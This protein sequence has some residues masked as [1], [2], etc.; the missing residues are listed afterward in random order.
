VVPIIGGSRLD[1]LHENLKAAT[2]RLSRDQRDRLDAAGAAQPDR[3]GEY[4]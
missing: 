2:V 3:E 4:R 1:Q